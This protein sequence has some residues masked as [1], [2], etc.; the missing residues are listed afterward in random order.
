MSSIAK[1]ENTTYGEDILIEGGVQTF[2]FL[3][4]LPYS[5]EI[6]QNISELIRN[7]VQEF[8]VEDSVSLL[9]VVPDGISIRQEEL[10]HEVIK[11]AG[12]SSCYCADIEVSRTI[13]YDFV[14][15]GAAFVGNNPTKTVSLL[16]IE[17]TRP[18]LRQ[19]FDASAELRAASTAMKMR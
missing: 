12:S 8:T 14:P 5:L 4:T 1:L 9:L 15:F 2:R 3:A 19:A 18:A 16:Q 7:Y 10:L 11:E 17:D 13:D 6:P